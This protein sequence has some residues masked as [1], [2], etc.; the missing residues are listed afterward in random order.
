M[1]D[2]KSIPADT[3]HRILD[4][5][6]RRCALCVHFHNDWGI[7]DGQ[8]AHLD[9]DPSNCT[10]DNLAYLCLPHH[11]DYDTKR[12]QTKNLTIREAKTARDRLYDAIERGQL[13]GEP[14]AANL[15][16]TDKATL[17]D[18]LRLMNGPTTRFLKFHA[19]A[20]RFSWDYVAG[21]ITIAQ[22]RREPQHEFLD[23]ELEEL[24]AT[25]VHSAAIL[26]S[27]LQMS[28]EPLP[29]ASGFYGVSSHYRAAFP[30]QYL[31][32]LKVLEQMQ[33][34]TR[35]AYELLIRT[36]RRKLG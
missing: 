30:D 33:T 24:R 4:R 16:S 15:Q 36:A 28:L 13:T 7:R 10:E 6:R 34:E 22:C 9:R 35:D 11:D 32:R 26:L 8:I 18:I 29:E 25:F 27:T 14:A 2:R 17:N 23:R 20:E 21:L 31:Q 19:F 12:R 5:S 1:A 3:E